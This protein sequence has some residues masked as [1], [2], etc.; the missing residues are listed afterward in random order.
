M[1]SAT[2]MTTPSAPTSHGGLKPSV[3][4]RNRRRGDDHDELEHLICPL[5]IGCMAIVP[6]NS[7]VEPLHRDVICHSSS[8]VGHIVTDTC[9]GTRRCFFSATTNHRACAIWSSPVEAY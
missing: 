3:P 6:L 5:V 7:L 9:F 1:P 4:D 2:A 8:T